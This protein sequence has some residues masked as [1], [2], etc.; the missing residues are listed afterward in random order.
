MFVGVQLLQV[1]HHP[2]DNNVIRLL[3]EESS[4][5]PLWVAILLCLESLHSNAPLAL[6]DD[7]PNIGTALASIVSPVS[8]TD[9]LSSSV[10]NTEIVSSPDGTTPLKLASNTDSTDDDLGGVRKKVKYLCVGDA[11]WE[12][13]PSNIDWPNRDKQYDSATAPD[14]YSAEMPSPPQQQ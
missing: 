5:V 2:F 3:P 14:I 7:I 6:Y 8:D 10:Y 12:D 9:I 4:A 1:K 13:I 11:V